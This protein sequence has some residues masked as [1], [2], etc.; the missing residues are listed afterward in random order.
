MSKSQFFKMWKPIPA[1]GSYK[2]KPQLD[3]AWGL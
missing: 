3:L 2:N 1:H